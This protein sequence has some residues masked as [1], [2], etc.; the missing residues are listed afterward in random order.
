MNR[1]PPDARAV[2]RRAIALRHLAGY[3]LSAPA[4]SVIDAV[5]PTWSEAQVRQFREDAREARDRVLRAL[6]KWRACLTR[7]EQA[8]MKRTADELSERDHIDASWRTEAV[9]VLAW[10]LCAESK[11]LPFDRQA[12]LKK[13]RDFASGDLASFVRRAKLRPRRE[14]DAARDMAEFW[15]WRSRTRELH[16]SG[17]PLDPDIS[18]RERGIETYEDIAR[19]AVSAARKRGELRTGQVSGGDLKAKGKAY[20]DLTD[21]EW[22]EVRSITVERHFTLNW[23]CGLAPRNSWEQTPTDT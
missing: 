7:R 20:R 12:S 22:D 23:L 5:M 6:G 11:L 8:I 2:A 21:S 16:E 10:A 17:K 13:Y 1:P 18:M 4:R 9:H 3:A 14:I 15:H 19:H